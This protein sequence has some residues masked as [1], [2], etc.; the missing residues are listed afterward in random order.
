MKV[1]FPIEQD[2]Y[3]QLVTALDR[4][5]SL[6]ECVGL[7]EKELGKRPLPG[8]VRRENIKVHFTSLRSL[9]GS[10]VKGD[11]CV[12]FS[13]VSKQDRAFRGIVDGFLD[14]IIQAMD[15]N[16]HIPF[17]YGWNDDSIALFAIPL[18]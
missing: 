15:S 4:G 7:L 13:I 1:P 11:T 10:R 5:A 9:D 12:I 6:G 3:D 8:D 16:N 14:T 18:W 2:A 17:C